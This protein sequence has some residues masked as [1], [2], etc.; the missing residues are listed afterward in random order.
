MLFTLQTY[1]QPAAISL[2]LA[3]HKQ[4]IDKRVHT[5]FQPKEQE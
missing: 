2:I 4:R 1:L 5:V 3:E